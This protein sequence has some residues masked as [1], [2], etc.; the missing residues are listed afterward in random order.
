M[1]TVTFKLP[2]NISNAVE[3]AADKRGV[4]KSDLIREAL[5]EYLANADST[6]K[7]SFTALSKDLIGVADGPP[8]LS[9]NDKHMQGYGS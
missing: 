8:D 2:E 3:T 4:S 7:N 5:V 9:S 6:S 1:K